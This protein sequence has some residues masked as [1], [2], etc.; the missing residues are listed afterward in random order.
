MAEPNTFFVQL[1]GPFTEDDNL[2]TLIELEKTFDI[3]DSSTGNTQQ[4]TENRF[5]KKIGIQITPE[6]SFEA[7]VLMPEARHRIQIGGSGDDI[8]T[9]G[10][11]GILEMDNLR[12]DKNELDN[13]F[14]FLQKEN[15][16]T[17]VDLVLDTNIIDSEGGK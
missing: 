10:A 7:Q 4:V 12:L 14:H 17:L 2:L 9:I 1:K 16:L 8:F 15:E 3:H 11:T 5:I 13:N 6:A